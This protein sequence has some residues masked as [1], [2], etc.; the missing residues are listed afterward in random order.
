MKRIATYAGLALLAAMPLQA[1]EGET[2]R[3]LMERGAELFFD[4]LRREMEPA[5]D[6]LK[7]LA[8]EMEPALREFVGEMG[9]A[10]A[11]ILDEIEDISDYHPPEMLPNGDIILRKKTPDEMADDP[12]DDEI[13]I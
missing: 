8:E 9:P 1:Q 4:G 7:G 10:L 13:E 2:G 5:L 12:M 6:D 3:S 11:D